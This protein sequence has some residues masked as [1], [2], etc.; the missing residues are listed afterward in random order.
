M[1]SFRDDSFPL[2]FEENDHLPFDEWSPSKCF[3]V[4]E[5]LIVNSGDYF[6]PCVQLKIMSIAIK[7]RGPWRF[8]CANDP[9]VIH[10]LWT[11][12]TIG[13]L[14][15]SCLFF[16][17]AKRKTCSSN[18][19][20]QK[21]LSVKRRT[22]KVITF[23]SGQTGTAVR[24][25]CQKMKRSPVLVSRSAH[26]SLTWKSTTCW[27]YWKWLY[28]KL[29]L[30]SWG[31]S[32]K[33][34]RLNFSVHNTHMTGGGWNDSLPTFSSSVVDFLAQGIGFIII[35]KYVAQFVFTYYMIL[36]YCTH[37]QQKK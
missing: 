18:T 12:S 3:A 11:L 29:L 20:T 13:K 33:L 23:H 17:A 37:T 25:I 9:Q 27:V 15:P 5:R 36:C 22:T 10:F 2:F 8:G 7:E 21:N 30:G 16:L 28:G 32:Q 34:N 35:W 6:L 31:A 26:T 19:F 24:E 4:R 14:L 1:T